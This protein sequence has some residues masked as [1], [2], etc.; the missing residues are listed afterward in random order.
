MSYNHYPFALTQ[1]LS[2][3]SRT[4]RKT[5]KYKRLE[6]VWSVALEE[7]LLQGLEAYRPSS[8]RDPSLLQRFPRRNK[9][10]SDF[11]F[12]QTGKTRTAKQVGSRLQQLRETCEDPEIISS[13]PF[14]MH[15]PLS[16]LS[17][18]SSPSTLSTA[19]SVTTSKS[20]DSLS[21]QSTSP[22]ATVPRQTKVSVA[23]V[24]HQLDLYYGCHGTPPSFTLDL[25]EHGLAESHSAA[26]SKFTR[27]VEISTT[28]QISQWPPTVRFSSV[29]LPSSSEYRCVSCVYRDGE[30]VY[31]DT[32][33]NKFLRPFYDNGFSSITY[34]TS[35]VPEYWGTLA[36]DPN[37]CCRYKI[38]QHIIPTSTSTS[39]RY[40]EHTLFS[41]DYNLEPEIVTLAQ[42]YDAHDLTPSMARDP[43]QFV[44][45]GQ[46]DISSSCDYGLLSG[47][48]FDCSD[49]NLSTFM[50]PILPQ[51]FR[52]SRL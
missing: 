26:S 41:I 31:T 24:I 44:P 49:P 3:T 40:S 16:P 4:G 52:Y 43:F 7:A 25:D 12:Q 36:C 45:N 6:P 38:T 10:I 14:C 11:I 46:Y 20:F 19:A 30:L 39:G 29:R 23:L 17:D 18:R 47:S 21:F 48:S 9:W 5:L 32:A 1:T 15:L 37:D 27:R 34:S 50:L 28:D 51:P 35:I 33:S 13:S 2:P 8:A 22:K 42:D